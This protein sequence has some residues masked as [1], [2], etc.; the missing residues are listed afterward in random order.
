M[1]NAVVVTGA[2]NGIGEAIAR[3][4][5]DRGWAVAGLDR[6]GQ[7]LERLRQE[8]GAAFV[9][10][11]GDVTRRADHERARQAAGETG[12]LAGWV[13][14]AGIERPTTARTLD[15]ADLQAIVQVNL[16]GTMLG[17]A[18]ATEALGGSGGSIV[19][20]SSIHSLAGFPESFVYAATK[21][22]IDAMTRQLAVEEAARGIRCNAVRPGAVMTPLTQSFLDA[23]DDPG[24][25][26]DEY[27]DLHPIRRLIEPVEIAR[28][29]AFLLSDEASFVNGES[30]TVDGGATARC[31]PYPG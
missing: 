22:G 30:I 24:A 4:L 20:M 6:D 5:V 7:G 21:G 19:N 8:L 18:V 16:I 11:T 3:L 14:N 17:C 31:Y 1:N 25:L 9:G 26:L 29:V 27:A 12:L 15:E 2:A 10:V 23:A 13:N 28:V